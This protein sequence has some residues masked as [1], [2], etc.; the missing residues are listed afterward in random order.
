MSELEGGQGEQQLVVWRPPAA[1]VRSNSTF[2]QDQ[3]PPRSL[4]EL[5]EPSMWSPASTPPPTPTHARP[6]RI[7][8]AGN[9]RVSGVDLGGSLF[10]VQCEHP[11]CD[12]VF[13]RQP[14]K[15]LVFQQNLFFC[16]SFL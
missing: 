6:L 10:R 14:S 5:P 3:I 9:P 7:R 13:M 1:S 16:Y 11:K 12:K 2:D 8:E 4:S 15:T